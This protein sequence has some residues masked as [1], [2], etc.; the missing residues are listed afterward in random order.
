VTSG[1]RP[2]VAVPLVYME[3]SALLAAL[4][5]G[6]VEAEATIRYAGRCVTSAL[7]FAEARRG[8]IRARV[9]GRLTSGRQRLA[10]QSLE[11]IENGCDV[12]SLTDDVL[13]RAGGPF[14]VEPIHTLDA[15]HLATAER[16][17]EPS[18]LVTVLSRDSRV[19]E[20]AAAM[21]F[22]LA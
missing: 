1:S 16:L 19:R 9:A 15:I 12:I 7:T 14:P 13:L 5:E 17:G 4:L 2:S 11:A 20:N 10:L 21:G 22:A 6:D 3:S 18:A 8:L